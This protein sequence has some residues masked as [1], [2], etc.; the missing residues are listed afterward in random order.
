MGQ[1]Y[2]R[3][4]ILLFNTCEWDTLRIPASLPQILMENNLPSPLYPGLSITDSQSLPWDPVIKS[5]ILSW[6]P[7][8][9]GGGAPF[10][11][12]ISF[13]RLSPSPCVQHR[14]QYWVQPNFKQR[15]RKHK[16]VAFTFAPV[17]Y[18][19]SWVVYS[20]VFLSICVV[21]WLPWFLLDSVW[22]VSL[23]EGG[24]RLPGCSKCVLLNLLCSY[25]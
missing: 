16:T 12:Q 17:P 21:P 18:R 11:L 4:L 1:Q 5:P 8:F 15:K 9:T 3:L 7:N 10:T 23:R 6:T 13:H 22:S 25:F 14:T 24:L 19:S 20:S 2:S